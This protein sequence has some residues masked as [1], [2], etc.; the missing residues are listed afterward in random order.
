MSSP[1][2][3]SQLKGLRGL[4]LTFP[5]LHPA[6]VTATPPLHPRLTPALQQVVP[7]GYENGMPNSDIGVR[8]IGHEGLAL[9]GAWENLETLKLEGLSLQGVS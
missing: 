3:L 2:A 8:A 1:Q 9:G 6:H 7:R 4:S 5:P